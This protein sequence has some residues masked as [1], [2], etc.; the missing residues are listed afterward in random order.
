MLVEK[1][2]D[3][4]NMKVPPL[5]SEMGAVD[6]AMGLQLN[7]LVEVNEAEQKV[8][9]SGWI[10]QYWFDPRLSYTS[11]NLR[12]LLPEH[13]RAQTWDSQKNFLSVGVERIWHP[14]TTVFNAVDYN[15]ANL[16]EPAEAWIYADSEANVIEVVDEHGQNKSLVFNVAWSKAC[17]MKTS[18]NMSLDWYPFDINEC[19]IIFEPWLDNYIRMHV[20]STR[21]QSAISLPEFSVNILSATAT[22]TAYITSSD[23]GHAHWPLVDVKINIERIGHYYV[24]NYIGPMLFMVM[25]SW[26]G[27]FI[28]TIA[29]DKL[30]YN[31][32]LVLL[33]LTVN[34]ITAEKRPPT[35]TDTWLDLF[36]SRITL[37]VVFLTFLQVFLQRL[38]P[39]KD[40]SDVEKDKRRL[41]MDYVLNIMRLVYPMVCFGVLGSGFLELFLYQRAHA[42]GEMTEHFAGTVP[43]LVIG[44]IVVVTV[45]M[46]LSLLCDHSHRMEMLEDHAW[47]RSDRSSLRRGRRKSAW[48]LDDQPITYSMTV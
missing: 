33:V 43:T 40:W 31:V 25:L 37:L 38:E 2:L 36:Q 26:I 19:S 29:S 3:G 12:P 24:V 4:Y 6:V 8:T 20:A 46:L 7:K 15:W 45:V 13:G 9:W 5:R 16:C 18:C 34:F 39:D 10:R 32:T 23:D 28:P 42:N 35:T 47:C 21:V 44:S 14:D 30:Q 22:Q 17:K 48:R 27:L 11:D 41:F 1:M